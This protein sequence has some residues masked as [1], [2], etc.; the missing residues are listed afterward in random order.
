MKNIT[1]SLAFALF[2][3]I[4]T[5]HVSAQT[6]TLN[7]DAT[8]KG[9][10]ISPTLY[11][12][13]YEE[14]NHAGDGGLYAELLRNRS[15]EEVDLGLRNTRFDNGRGER[16]GRPANPNR[17]PFWNTVNGASATPVTEGLMNE[18]QK[19]GMLLT[20]EDASKTSPAGVYNQ[21]YWG[22]PSVKGNK[23]TLTFWARAD[24]KERLS[25][26]VGLKENDTWLAKKLF[27]KTVTPE[28][29]KYK[30]TFKAN[31]EGSDA[32]FY[33]LLNQPATLCLDLV[34]LFPPTY[35]GRPNGCRRDLAEKLEALQPKFLRFPGGCFV[36][37]MS[38][39]TAYDW[40]KTIGP[41]EERPGHM[42]AN[43]G[44]LCTD[45][46]GYHEYLQLAEDLGAEP[47]YVVNVGIWHGGFQPYDSI[48]AYIQDALDALEYAN[49][50]AS[51]YWGRQRISNGHRKPFG[52][53]LM[54]IGNENYQVNPS[55]QSD[56][57]AERYI[58]FYKAIKEKYP[59]VQIIGNVES[60][61]TDHPT[62]RNEHPV[63]LLD[64][65]YYRTPAWFASK[66]H[67]Y[68]DYDRN[69]PRIYVGEYAVT[70]N[71]G[72][73]N[74]QAALGEAIY[75]MG[76]EI[77]SDIVSMASY[78]PIFVNW[79]DRHWMPDMIRYDAAQSWVSPSYYVQK[80][81]AE[82]VGTHIVH[83]AL[84]QTKQEKPDRFR[85]GLGAWNTAVE[86]K[87]LKVT[88]PEGKTLYEQVPVFSS[89][90]P[91][92]DI[93]QWNISGGK[94]ES[95]LTDAS[96]TIRQTAIQEN[97][98][99]ICP[100]EMQG[101]D[102]DVTVEARKTGGDE[103]FL[104][105]FDHTGDNE[106]RW[107]NVAGWGNSQH[108]VE[109]IY[110][111]GKTQP[112]T[113]RG[114]IENNRWYTLKVEVRGNHIATYL[115]GAKVHDFTS[116]A[117]DV[118]YANAETDDKTGNLIV[119]IVNFGDEDQPVDIHINGTYRKGYTVSTLQGDAKDENTPDA[120]HTVEPKT[121]SVSTPF[122]NDTQFLAPANS[123]SIIRLKK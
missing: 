84:S 54:E 112:A 95:N 34:S 104:L 39:E 42:N 2:L 90:W 5:A 17:L 6:A 116:E 19:R 86:Y 21:G 27:K 3:I 53:R 47:L 4:T 105:I 123:L 71:C 73:G 65:H 22:I 45:G 50:D 28:W 88:T 7:I 103:G 80:M 121:E 20:V 41:L 26:T 61:G 106:Y 120:P 12:L 68:D 111:G 72:E 40:K 78:A 100:Q 8:Q 25:F 97:C 110:N 81:M 32:D 43:W 52:L 94:W 31:A 30:V 24:K 108:A 101:R 66:Y 76:M 89:R 117:P 91:S 75:M 69:G 64:E 92:I 114:H 70:S 36:E 74:L 85:V 87:G 29:K 55:E 96:A 93:T 10:D 35:K 38:R 18:A 1:R 16:F 79:H 57:Y 58:Q 107:F 63:D 33:L 11:G 13:F 118:L 9:I 77:N 113:S 82:N 62:W 44:Y 46:M 48:D 59:E 60:W 51:T 67:H 122:G 15:F 49:G 99:A 115:D 37:G 102:Y 109:D 23:Y 119:K 98:V 14:I 56:H 83:S